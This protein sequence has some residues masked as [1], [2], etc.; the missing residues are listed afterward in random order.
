MT[1]YLLISDLHFEH[2]R[3]RTEFSGCF[4]SKPAD[5]VLLAG[6]I[7]VGTGALPFI[8][9][10]L[11]LD[12]EVVY[13]MGNHEFYCHDI[14]DTLAAWQVIAADHPKLHILNNQSCIIGDT[15]I[16]GTTLWTSLD[17]KHRDEQIEFF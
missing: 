17:T 2:D 3:N 12:C 15:E 9:H 16:F 14:D 11:H 8:R 13:I 7:G 10:L 6:D 1:T 5:V 4:A